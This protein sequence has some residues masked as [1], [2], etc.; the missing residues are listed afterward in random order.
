M[1]DKRD[2]YEVL[3]V[4]RDAKEDEIKKAFRTLAKKWHPDR[5]PDNRNDA[6]KKFKEAA[7]AYEV[8]RDGDKRRQYDTY[9]HEG[10]SGAARV[11]FSGVNFEDLFSS[12]FG[13]GSPF[14]GSIFGDMFG[15]G[16]PVGRAYGPERGASLRCEVTIPFEEAAKG[17]S[18][19]IELV[20]S[21]NCPDCKGTGAEGGTAMTRCATCN[22]AGNVTQSR[23]FFT[24]RSTCPR[25]GGTGQMIEKPCPG[26]SGSGH[27]RKKAKIEIEI[28]AG[29]EDGTRMRIGGEGEEGPGGGPRGDLYCYVYVKSHEFFMRHGDDIVLEVPITFT[30]AALGADIEVPTL[31]GKAKVKVPAGT[32]SGKVLRLRGQGMPSPYGR[33]RGDELVQVLIETPR[34]LSGKQEEILREYAKTEK[35][36]V[37]PMRKS[38]FDKLKDYFKE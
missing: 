35:V 22:G 7:E 36:N 19:T 29:I 10:L 5:N 32:Q 17:T 12:F 25:C 11:D 37:S 18:R 28:P 23:G 33:G 24:M 8:L 4:E 9:G 30:Q 21:D 14:G 3:G 13:R 38:F 34:K 27:I 15:G 26:C 16:V 20:R 2:Y 31:G 1:A 6:E